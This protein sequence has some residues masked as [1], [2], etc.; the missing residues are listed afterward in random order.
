MRAPNQPMSL[1]FS[2]PLNEPHARVD[3]LMLL[4]LAGLM[5]IGVFFVYS[6][7]MVS[8]SAALVPWYNQAWVRQI[9]WCVLGLGA[10]TAMS[11]VDY[12]VVARWSA[13]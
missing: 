5:F 2:P 8:E 9:F 12:R 3:W 13:K 7:T 4:A 10:M 6:A 1:G 11:L